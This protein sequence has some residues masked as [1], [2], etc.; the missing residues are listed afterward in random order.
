MTDA[1]LAASWPA[2]G[3]LVAALRQQGHADFANRLVDRVQYAS[4][5]GEIYN[6][7]GNALTENRRLRRSLDTPANDAWESTMEDI[8]RAYNMPRPM[9]WLMRLWRRI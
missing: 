2:L 4:T 8:E 3:S 5:S 9:R 1:E 7:V 6:G